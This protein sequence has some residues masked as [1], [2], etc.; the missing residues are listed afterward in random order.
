MDLQ[1]GILYIGYIPKGLKPSDLKVGL[2]SFGAISRLYLN[3]QSSSLKKVGKKTGSF[4]EGWVEFF[5]KQ[6]AMK[7]SLLNMQPM[8]FSKKHKDSIW[9][10]KFL[11]FFTWKDLSSKFSY[12]NAYKDSIKSVE[13]SKLRRETSDYISRYKKS[14]QFKISNKNMEK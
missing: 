9:N 2:S 11:E 7:A 14:K 10:V 1:K 5:D 3:P 6:D 8:H 13:R 4:K 12:E